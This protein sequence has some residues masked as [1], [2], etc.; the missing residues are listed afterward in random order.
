METHINTM[1]NSYIRLKI[2]VKRSNVNED[3]LIKR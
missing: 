3:R 1:Y 2:C